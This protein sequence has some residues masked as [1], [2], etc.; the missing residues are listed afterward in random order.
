MRDD[1]E[2]IK[3][4]V[5]KAD[6]IKV[7]A[8]GDLHFGSILHQE[9]AWMDFRD[10]L[11]KESNSYVLLLGDLINNNTK[12]AVGSPFE[13]QLRP[14]EQKRIMAE[15]LKPL[16]DKGMILAAV[17]GNHEK[18]SL[19][20]ADDDPMY[21]IM[22]KLDLEDKFRQNAAFIHLSIGD[23]KTGGK[24][25]PGASYN[26]AMT[27]GSGGG[28]LTGSAVNKSERFGY[29]FENIDVLITGHTHKGVIT[30]PGKYV[31]N[32][33]EGRMVFKP[34]VC[35]S[36]CSWMNYGG[37]ALQKM[38]I[39]ASTAK[40]GEKLLYFSGDRYNKRVRTEW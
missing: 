36:A 3:I 33:T 12:N 10:S 32:A 7:R 37:Y 23:R 40:D 2:I 9:K 31:F 35:I 28:V 5:P 26:L 14:M 18:R 20:D 29:T 11:L 15:M 27:H 34:F 8:I 21:D 39:P 38:L 13:D 30:K 6:W 16:A 22:A 25:F 1:L 17:S 24:S 19:K 4:R